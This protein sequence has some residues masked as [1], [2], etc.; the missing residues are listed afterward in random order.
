VK[1]RYVVGARKIPYEDRDVAHAAIT[2]DDD[3]GF[4]DVIGADDDPDVP[5]GAHVAY[6]AHLTADEATRFRA[7]SN[8]RYVELDLAD[9]AD[10]VTVRRAPGDTAADLSIP[11]SATMAYLGAG[12]TGVEAW[13]GRDVTIGVMDGGTTPAVKRRFG[14][15][16]VA[17][18]DFVR[19][20]TDTDQI[21]TEHGCYVTPEAVPPG[22]R[23]A[24]A[25][26]FNAEGRSLH[27]QTTAAMKWLCDVGAK[28]INYSGSGT[29]SS[30]VQRDGLDYARQRGVVLVCSAGNDGEYRLGYPAKHCEDHAN[31][32]SSIAFVEASDDRADFSNHLD[33]GSGCAPGSRSLSVNRDAVNIRWSG[34]SSSAPKMARLVAMG[35]TSGRFTTLEVARALEVNA[36][37]TEEP[38]AEEGAGAWH[39][40]RALRKLGVFDPPPPPEPQPAPPLFCGSRF[41]Y[42]YHRIGA[43]WWVRCIRMFE[44][45][46]AAEA[47]G[48]R[49]CRICKP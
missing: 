15:T 11:P 40:E 18:R 34:T 36:R 3:R 12:F 39:L 25:I 8:C 5:V 48:L 37:D 27:S 7:A 29:S 45:R 23:L 20:G 42:A 9:T 17:Q 33:T 1:E 31:V 32:K 14:W 46:A 49:P 13:H 10:V 2:A 21:T 16:V 41:G 30:S 38:T 43:H 44:S 22:G 4:A 6:V 28:V 47:A 19:G 24:E 35:A 26:V